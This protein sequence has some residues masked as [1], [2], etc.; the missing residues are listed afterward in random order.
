MKLTTSFRELAPAYDA[1]I[2]DLWGVLHDGVTAF[3][4]AV[5]CLEHLREAGTAIAILSNAPR[6]ATEVEAK[7]NE[8]G[9]APGLYDLVLSSGEVAWRHLKERDD[10]WYAALGQRCFHLGPDRD[11]GMRAGLDYDFVED[12]DEADFLLN[13]GAHMPEDT[14]ETYAH[15]LDAGLARHLPMVCANPDLV[16]VRGGKREICAGLLAQRYEERGG[17]VRYHGKPHRDVYD[18]CLTALNGIVR[19]RIAA[20]GD[21]L[22]TDIAGA[23]AAG[24]DAIWVLGGIHA[25]ELGL[26]DRALPPADRLDT[27]AREAGQRPTAALPLFHW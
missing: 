1:L 6:R 12:P 21:S 16:V 23:A 2:V 19:S 17:E 8:L 11:R 14:V 18:E 25:E 15:E 20:V 3:P 22:R 26:S 4:D 10:P 27:M 24:M 7:M 5:R 13:T 9:I